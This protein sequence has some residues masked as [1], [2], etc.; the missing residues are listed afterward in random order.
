VTVAAKV[1]QAVKHRRIDAG[2]VVEPEV[3]RRREAGACARVIAV[4]IDSPGL[5]P[6]ALA[7]L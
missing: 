3:A 2:R 5:K 7:C 1:E 6:F 4:T